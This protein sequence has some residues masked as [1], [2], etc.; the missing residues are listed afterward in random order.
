MQ[1][2]IINLSWNQRLFNTRGK[3]RAVYALSPYRSLTGVFWRSRAVVRIS[4]T[5]QV[6]AESLS[7]L[8]Y[9]EPCQSLFPSIV[10][11]VRRSYFWTRK[12][13]SVEIRRQ[14]VAV[15]GGVFSQARKKTTRNRHMED[16]GTKD[17]ECLKSAIFLINNNWGWPKHVVF[18]KD[19]CTV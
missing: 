2:C 14:L 19:F 15:Y 11:R 16:R 4:A 10:S 7:E 17:H 1:V 13:H 9:K 6:F 8:L 5:S 12:V 18:F 3:A